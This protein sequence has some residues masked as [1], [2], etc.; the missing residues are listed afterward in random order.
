MCYTRLQH[1]VY[2]NVVKNQKMKYMDKYSE[3]NPSYSY[4]VHAVSTLFYSTLLGRREGA[5]K[6]STLCTLAKLLKIM[7]D[8]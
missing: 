3:E 1:S 4:I 8:P 6:K 7:N 2:A 5:S